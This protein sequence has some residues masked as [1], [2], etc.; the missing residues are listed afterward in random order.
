[1]NELTLIRYTILILV[2]CA[3]ATLSV[4]YFIGI[5]YGLCF[6]AGFSLCGMLFAWVLDEIG[7]S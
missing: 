2:I 7:R 1:M 4:I 3:L 5:E 6:F